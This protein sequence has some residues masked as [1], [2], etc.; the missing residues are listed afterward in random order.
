MKKNLFVFAVLALCTV[1]QTFALDLKTAEAKLAGPAM[2]EALFTVPGLT[3]DMSKTIVKG[4]A[5]LQGIVT[6]KPDLEKT[7][8]L[9]VF[10]PD[11]CKLDQVKEA[12]TKAAPNAK[13][14][15]SGPASEQTKKDCS[16]CPS[17]N[18][19]TKEKTN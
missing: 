13:F 9:V 6:S 17:R 5:E 11:K 7:T 18:T 3:A 15:K 8:M 2:E 19:C 1:V 14:E 4:L 12:M 10:E 16:K